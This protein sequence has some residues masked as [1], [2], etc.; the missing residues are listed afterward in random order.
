MKPHQKQHLKLGKAANYALNNYHTLIVYTEDDHTPQ[1]ITMMP[2]ID[3]AEKT[4]Y[5]QNTVR[6]KASADLFTLI[7][8]DFEAL[9]PKY[10]S[11]CV[12]KIKPP[13]CS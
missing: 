1:L 10:A 9:T 3:K 11:F 12:P 13:N 8:R 6:D 4:G 7:E 2:I 5:S